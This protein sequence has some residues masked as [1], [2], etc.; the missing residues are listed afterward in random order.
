MEHSQLGFQSS[1]DMLVP[2]EVDKEKLP[3]TVASVAC[4]NKHTAVITTL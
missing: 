2:K 1:E 3:E 4:G